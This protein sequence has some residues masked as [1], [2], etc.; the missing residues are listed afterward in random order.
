V[1]EKPFEI[2]IVEDNPGDAFLAQRCLKTLKTPTNSH[3]IKN[4]QAA[5]AFLRK[6]EEFGGVP[7]PDLILLDLNLPVKDGR[8]ALAEIKA[9]EKLKAIPVI[10][11]T[12][13]D[14]ENDI[15][16]AY[17]LHANSYLCKPPIYEDFARLFACLEQYWFALSRLP[18]N[19]G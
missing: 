3:W 12:S 16:T 8:E 9:D 7:R 15:A 6:E 5:M 11:L 19:P 4:G 17:R 10:I 13:S 14:S 2:L 18:S 1:N